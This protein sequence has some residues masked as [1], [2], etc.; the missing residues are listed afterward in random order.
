MP[1][2]LS[3]T[4]QPQ[5]YEL[6][7]RHSI[8]FYKNKYK[9]NVRIYSRFLAQKEYAKAL[10]LMFSFFNFFSNSLKL[11]RFKVSA[12]STG[13]SKKEQVHRS[14]LNI[15]KVSGEKLTLF[16]PCF[17]NF[18]FLINMIY[19]NF[20]KFNLKYFIKKNR[21]FK[22]QSILSFTKLS[23]VAAHSLNKINKSQASRLSY[24]VN[25]FGDPATN[26]ITNFYLRK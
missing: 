8:M 7:D 17:Q 2:S 19:L 15:V 23:N 12:L 4:I 20:Y 14:I 10:E 3:N 25:F 16:S 26:S 11:T 22:T 13:F 18:L 24:L 1:F 5:L 6:S 9:V 21:F